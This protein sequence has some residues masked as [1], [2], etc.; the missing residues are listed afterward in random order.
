MRIWVAFAAAERVKFYYMYPSSEAVCFLQ[1]DTSLTRP[2]AYTDSQRCVTVTDC[3]GNSKEQDS[4][5]RRTSFTNLV[6][7]GTA[8]TMATQDQ[9]QQ[10]VQDI[11]TSVDREVDNA[12]RR[13]R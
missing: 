10:S 11:S 9:W 6:G 7:W 8:G 1:G 3:N 2:L 4:V 5:T 12:L 13:R